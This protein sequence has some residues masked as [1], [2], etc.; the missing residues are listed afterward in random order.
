M[1]PNRGG[2]RASQLL[3]RYPYYVPR[4]YIV[5]LDSE[6]RQHLAACRAEFSV[7]SQRPNRRC[8]LER[9]EGKEGKKTLAPPRAESITPYSFSTTKSQVSLPACQLA[10][11]VLESSIVGSAVQHSPGPTGPPVHKAPSVPD[12]LTSSPGRGHCADSA[13][14]DRESPNAVVDDYGLTRRL[15]TIPTS[16]IE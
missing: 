5:L 9:L 13:G 2:P 6:E 15:L 12:F 3:P 16:L 8:R 10:W 7:V 1:Q 4:Y 14:G 11:P